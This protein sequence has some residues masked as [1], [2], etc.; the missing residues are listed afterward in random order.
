MPRSRPP[1][2]SSSIASKYCSSTS[3]GGVRGGAR[4]AAPSP[5]SRSKVDIAAIT[6]V[7]LP[8]GC[9]H[10]SRWGRATSRGAWKDWVGWVP[11][12]QASDT[13]CSVLIAPDARGCPRPPCMA[14]LWGH[15]RIARAL[16]P[17]QAKRRSSPRD[18]CRRHTDA[19]WPRVHAVHGCPP[20]TCG[21]PD[22]LRTPCTVCTSRHGCP[23]ATC[24]RVWSP[25]SE[26]LR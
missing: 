24:T 25:R 17:Q 6:Q 10:A 8:Y 16:V 23:L 4:A 2:A 20:A 11:Q 7:R 13:Q 15:M 3:G 18:R 5:Y 19:L 9:P 21:S 12:K 26:L 1:S 14:A 22:P